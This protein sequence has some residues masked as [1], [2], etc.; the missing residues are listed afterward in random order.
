VAAG[1]IVATLTNRDP[2]KGALIE[3][4][5]G[6]RR[7]AIALVGNVSAA[8]DL[9]QDCIERALSRSESLRELSRIGPWLRAIL[10]NLYVDRVR[11]ENSEGTGTELDLLENDYALSTPADDRAVRI[12]FARAFGRLT[13]EHRQILLLAG[14]EGLSYREISAELSIPIGTV[15]SRLARAREGLRNALERETTL[16]TPGL[17][18]S[19]G[20]VR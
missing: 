4:L 7:Y 5:P 2:F 17:P 6:L 13:L 1:R 12:D 15:M 19:Q 14:L 8:E 10:H 20:R 9:V 3:A 11:R 18:K 16:A